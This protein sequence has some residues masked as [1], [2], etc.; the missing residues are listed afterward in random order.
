VT[1]QRDRLR[2]PAKIDGPGLARVQAALEAGAVVALPTDTVYGLAVLPTLPGA[3][4]RLF[5]LK[6]RPSSIAVAVL[7]GDAKQAGRVMK[8]QGLAASLA[9]EFWPGALTI[10]GERLA[11]L[12]YELGGDSS[13]IGVRCP[14]APYIT[15]LCRRVGPIAVTSANRHGEAPVDSAAL[16]RESFGSQL[17]I[18]DGGICTGKP[19]TVVDVRGEQPQLLRA[20]AIDFEAIA[21]IATQPNE[22]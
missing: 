22:D 8:L 18:A 17:L 13:S 16:L 12:P 2:V 14:N 9:E 1:D 7:V 19:S 15:E 5:E 3:L 4:Q 21:A 20:G 6:G 10:V 11:D